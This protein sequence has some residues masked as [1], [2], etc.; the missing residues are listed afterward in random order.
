MALID[1][2]DRLCWAKVDGKR[3]IER[4]TVKGMER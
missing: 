2:E 1:P 4:K 3:K